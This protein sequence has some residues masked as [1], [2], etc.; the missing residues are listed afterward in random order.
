[1]NGDHSAKRRKVC[2]S[3]VEK[4]KI[5]KIPYD[6]WTII[7]QFYADN[8]KIRPSCDLMLVC[9]DFAKAVKGRPLFL[10]IVLGKNGLKKNFFDIFIKTLR[11]K[12]PI[13]NEHDNE[14]NEISL[15][16]D[17]QGL[18]FFYLRLDKNNK[19]LQSFWTYVEKK[20]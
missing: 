3:A 11:F 1:M 17:V 12:K 18:T 15:Y 20:Q 5:K 4:T 16:G 7:F 14:F 2:T 10:D 6:C 9:K 8:K 13:S 19:N